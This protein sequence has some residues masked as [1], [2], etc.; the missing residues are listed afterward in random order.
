L[1]FV[2]GENGDGKDTTQFE[3]HTETHIIIILL[4]LHTV[5]FL[6]ETRH[7]GWGRK[8]ISLL[9]FLFVLRTCEMC[10]WEMRAR[11]MK[12]KSGDSKRGGE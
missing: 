9:A 5:R 6:K 8:L 12:G 10:V 4:L 7:I 1:V 2:I 3:D 11:S